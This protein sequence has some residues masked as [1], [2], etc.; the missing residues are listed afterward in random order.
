MSAT[1]EELAAVQAATRNGKPGP[2]TALEQL[3]ILWALEDVSVQVRRARIFGRGSRAPVEVDLSNE[4]TMTFDSIRD[5]ARPANLL[6]ELVACTGAMPKLNQ[7]QALRSVSLVR[8]LAERAQTM[9]ENEI[10]IDWGATYLQAAET[11]DVDLNNQG[12]RWAVVRAHPP[13]RPAGPGARARDGPRRRRDRS[14][15]HGWQPPRPRR[16]VLPVRPHDRRQH[17]ADAGRAHGPRRL[18]SSRQD[19]ADQS[20]PARGV[21]EPRGWNFWVVPAGWEN[22]R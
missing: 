6:A 8:A 12:D 3:R 22:D 16:L 14:S 19:G 1:V 4:E 18:D 2:S 5:M 11:L 9:T 20:N 10:A 17:R 7:Q 13:A 15:P 21:S